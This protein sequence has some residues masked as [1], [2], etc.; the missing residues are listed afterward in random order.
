MKQSTFAYDYLVVGAG[1]FGA[2]FANLAGKVGKK[3][4][5]IDKRFHIGGNIYTHEV[6]GI[7]VHE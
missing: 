7:P 5:V 1:L 4:L 3:C 2:V 6:E